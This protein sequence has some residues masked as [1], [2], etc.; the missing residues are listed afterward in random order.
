MYL[1]KTK[2]T[3]KIPD[4]VQIRD[5]NFALIANIRADNSENTLKHNGFKNI[6]LIVKIINKLSYGKLIKVDPDVTKQIN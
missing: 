1:L 5:E 2:G 4:Y 6:H 3:D